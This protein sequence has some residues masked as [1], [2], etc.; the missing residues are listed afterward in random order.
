MNV[1]TTRNQSYVQMFVQFKDDAITKYTVVEAQAMAMLIC[2]FNRRMDSCTVQVGHQ[3]LSTYSLNKGIYKFG[4]KG[5]Q[6][7]HAEMKQLKDQKCFIPIDKTILNATERKRAIESLNFLTE[8]KDGTIKARHCANGSTERSYIT[9]EEASSP[10]VSTDST[11]MTAVIDAE[12]ER[13]VAT[14]DI[15]N[16]FIQIDVE[17]KDKD[18]NRT[19]MKI[20]GVL[21]DILCQLDN[22]YKEYV[23]T[24]NGQQVLY[25]HVLKAIYGMLLSSLLFYKK[26]ATDLMSYGFVLN[27][28]D[29]CVANKFV[30]RKQITVSWHVDDLKVIHEDKSTID[31]FIEWVKLTYGSIGTVKV[32]R[33]SVHDYL[34]MTLDYRVKG[35]V[36]I[37][38]TGYVEKMIDGFPQQLDGESMI[39]WNDSLFKVNEEA[40]KLDRHQAENFHTVVAQGL[41]LC[42]RGRPDIAPAIAFLS[43]R[44]RCPDEEDWQK[45]VRL[46]KFLK[47]TRKDVL[48]LK[49]SSDKC[50]KWYADA[51]FAVHPDFKSHTGATMTMGQ[52]AVMSMSR[53]QKLNARSSTEAELIA[54]DEV[55]VP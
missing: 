25:V 45:L 35:Q 32:C 27:P 3:F 20:R 39:P 42:N 43:T 28:Y 52:G 48:T 51:S 55:V 2:E 37:D 19:I 31:D 49:A 47:A 21:V 54:A 36:S 50:I 44:V 22:S 53:K 24:K 23:V 4:E 11:T 26:L 12:E 9:R 38:M 10:T 41:F 29:P 40:I 18:G 7:A 15:P 5:Q 16:A 8:K 14:C 34:G 17:E 33:G 13:E 46:M 6:A 30:D 1:K